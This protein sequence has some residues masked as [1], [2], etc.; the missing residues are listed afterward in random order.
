MSELTEYTRDNYP[1]FGK[2]Y[3][4]EK[5]IISLTSWTARINTVSKTLFSLLQ[6][7]PGFHIV[8]VLSEEE[9]P[10]MM[11]ELPENL[12]LFVNNEL[13]EVLFAP[14]NLRPHLKYFYTMQKYRDAPIITAD[15]DQ[16]VFKNFAEILY[17]SYLKNP[18]VIHGGRCHL[19]LKKANTILPY[20]KWKWDCKSINK[21]SFELFATGVGTV[22]YPPNILKL[23]DDDLP[24]IKDMLCQD[25][26]FFKNKR[27]YIRYK[28]T[29]C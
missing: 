12:K 18:N 17:T 22:L 2:K 7:C 1:S 16:I 15:D 27:K 20:N 26:I 24:M 6:Q 10:K 14:E 25:D 13:I 9:F 23:S 19:I 29:I 4:G 5:A 8:L 3:N 11:D 21:P 28:G